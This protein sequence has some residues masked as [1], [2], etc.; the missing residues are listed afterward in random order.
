MTND[1]CACPDC[2]GNCAVRT[3]LVKCIKCGG[4]KRNHRQCQCE[5]PIVF[6]HTRKPGDPTPMYEADE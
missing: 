4:M 1:K 3:G 6:T 2:K 5:E